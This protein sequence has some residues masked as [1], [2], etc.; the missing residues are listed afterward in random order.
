MRLLAVKQLSIDHLLLV[1]VK[2]FVL[3]VL[4]TRVR[5]CLPTD[6]S[7]RCQQW[8]QQLGTDHLLVRE[9]VK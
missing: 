8:E 7:S 1:P 6:E 2:L 5:H 3:P 9:D 4:N